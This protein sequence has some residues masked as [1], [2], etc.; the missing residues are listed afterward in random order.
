VIRQLLGTRAEHPDATQTAVVTSGGFTSEAM[1]VATQQG[2]TM[3]DGNRLRNELDRA[4]LP[5]W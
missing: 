2:V 5:K 3:I 1:Q 4:G